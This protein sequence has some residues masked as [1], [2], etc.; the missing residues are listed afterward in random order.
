M[1]NEVSDPSLLVEDAAFLPLTTQ[2]I[3]RLGELLV[4][5]KLLRYGIDSSP[6]TTDSGVDLVAYSSAKGRSFTIQVK[7]NLRPKQAG[8]KGSPGIDWW[9]SEDCP[10]ELYA[11]ADISTRRIWLLTKEELES[12]VRQRSSGR[13]HF[14]MY[15]KR[16][17]SPRAY[18]SNGDELYSE[19]LF[20]NKVGSLF[21]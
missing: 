3:G 13:L 1:E 5:F 18:E 6:M 21:L 2:K 8:G 16:G 7:T 17:S 12:V 9:V 19:F 10:A 4:Q 15:T 14:G 11:F 20:E